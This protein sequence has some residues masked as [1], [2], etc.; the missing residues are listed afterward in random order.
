[1]AKQPKKILVLNVDIDDDVYEK[2]KIKGPVVGRKQN[3]EAASKLALADPEDTDSNAIFEA[4]KTYDLFSKDYDVEVATLTGDK[5]LGFKANQKVLNQ[6]EAVQKS[7]H[8]EAYIYVSDGESDDRIL[9]LLKTRIDIIDVKTVIVKQSKELEKTYFTILDKLKDPHFAR[10]VFGIP[11]L[12]L[13]VYALAEVIALRILLGLFGVY[14]IIKAFG[15]EEKIFS[16]FSELKFSLNKVSLIF[17]FVSFP[18]I[19]ISLWLGVSAISVQSFSNI[20]TEIAVFVKNF[21]LLFPIAILFIIAGKVLDIIGEKKHYLLPEYLTLISAILLFWL[22]FDYAADWV[23]GT[24]AFADFLI[25]S[26][27]ITTVMLLIMFL[28]RDF[29]ASIVG[30]IPLDGKNVYTEFGAEIGKIVGVNKKKQL[31]IIQNNSGVKFDVNIN[32]ISSISDKVT[33][34]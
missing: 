8:P 11:G 28:S 13:L 31:I 29:K 15:V 26:L 18:L 10:I 27:L 6:L 22:L 24:I 2:T 33:L 12:I 4:V 9:P 7:F 16:G 32:R 25:A 30:R 20:A 3:I 1:M 5:N 34:N 23:I 21:L 14:L 17:Y 19:I